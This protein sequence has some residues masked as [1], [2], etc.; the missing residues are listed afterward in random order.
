MTIV[1]GATRHVGSVTAETLLVQGE[2][3]TVMKNTSKTPI[4]YQKFG[5]EIVLT[6]NICL[7]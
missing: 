1:L 2:P 3:V 6:G 5:A 7:P 4:I